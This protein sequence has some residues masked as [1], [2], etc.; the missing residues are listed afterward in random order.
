M[1]VQ[2]ESSLLEFSRDVFL[3]ADKVN[4]GCAM[5]IGQQGRS[6]MITTGAD[7]HTREYR[8]QSGV[9]GFDSYKL[10]YPIGACLPKVDLATHQL[11]LLE[12]LNKISQVVF[13][14]VFDD[15]IVISKDPAKSW[16]DH[17]ISRNIYEV[18]SAYLGWPGLDDVVFV[19]FA[20]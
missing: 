11:G 9:L 17:G 7:G 12:K 14:E 1:T 8:F 10:S 15:T 6:L 4:E 19:H 13:I 18:I 16:D 5:N 3:Q 20:I 2:N